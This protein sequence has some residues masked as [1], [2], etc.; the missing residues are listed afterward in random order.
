MAPEPGNRTTEAVMDATSLY[1]EETYTD[2]KIG[3]LRVLT[4]VK[5]DGSPDPAR[6]PLFQGEAQLMTNMGPLPISFDIDARTLAEAV[7]GYA[8]ATKAGIERAMREL[9]DM[10]RQASSSIVLPPA[11]ATLPPGGPLGGGKIQLP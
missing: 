1:R 11:G 9:Q 8:E 10:R 7:E 5:S 6:P 4:P 3:T 2:R